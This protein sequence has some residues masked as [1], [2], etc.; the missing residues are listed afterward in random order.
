MLNT[1]RGGVWQSNHVKIKRAVRRR[2]QTERFHCVEGR[3]YQI[4]AKLAA[5]S[6]K[7]RKR[8]LVFYCSESR[9]VFTVVRPSR[10]YNSKVGFNVPR[11][12]L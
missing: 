4:K 9:K 2:K 7:R 5:F 10:D 6:K 11:M 3:I 8:I 12:K 1:I